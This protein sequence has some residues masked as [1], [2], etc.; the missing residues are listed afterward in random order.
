M[1]T[2][3]FIHSQTGAGE[4]LKTAERVTGVFPEETLTLLRFVAKVG[5]IP[6]ATAA[7]ALVLVPFAL[8]TSQA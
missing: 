2:P 6:T 3:F 8:P 5:G 1:I 4:A 7:A